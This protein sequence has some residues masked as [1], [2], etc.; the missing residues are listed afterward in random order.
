MKSLM[1]E[2]LALKATVARGA[3][4]ESDQELQDDADMVAVAVRNRQKKLICIKSPLILS[5]RFPHPRLV[6]RQT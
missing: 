4:V 1:A 6:A 5:I 2:N 3:Q